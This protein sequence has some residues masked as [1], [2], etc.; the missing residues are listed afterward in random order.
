M[1]AYEHPQEYRVFFFGGV[2]VLLCS[3]CGRSLF[4]VVLQ[5][6]SMLDKREGRGEE[7]TTIANMRKVRAFGTSPLRFVRR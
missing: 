5:V 1:R 3:L 6:N 2:S 4:R 7:V